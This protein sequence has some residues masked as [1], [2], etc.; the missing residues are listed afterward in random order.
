MGSDEPM[1]PQNEQRINS[2]MLR[3]ATISDSTILLEWRNDFETQE[4]SHNSSKILA[5]EHDAWFAKTITNQSRQI[6]MAIEKDIAVGM[7]RLDFR[8]EQDDYLLSWTVAPASRGRGIGSKILLEV[9]NM[10]CKRRLVAEIKKT[11]QPSRAMVAKCGFE[12]LRSESD[13]EV[14]VRNV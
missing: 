10:Y 9:S 2:I 12:L 6:F 11:N 14:W 5:S 3:E 4:N 8:A 7:I 1:P 13:F